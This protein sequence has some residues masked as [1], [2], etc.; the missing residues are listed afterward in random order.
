[1][2]PLGWELSAIVLGRYE[3]RGIGELVIHSM[4]GIARKDSAQEK[5]R[6][7]EKNNQL[8]WNIVDLCEPNNENETIE[9]TEK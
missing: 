5:W 2:I 3:R 8:W 9:Q 4:P 6:G 1:M 7:K